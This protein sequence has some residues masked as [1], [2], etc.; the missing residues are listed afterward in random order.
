MGHSTAIVKLDLNELPAHPSPRTIMDAAVR[1]WQ[2]EEADRWDDPRHG[3]PELS[4]IA[5]ER[6]AYNLLEDD[7]DGRGKSQIIPITSD[8]AE[9]TSTVRLEVTAAE[10]KELRRGSYYRFI[11]EGRFGKAVVKVE[12]AQLPK[13]RAPRAAAT[14]GKAVTLYRIVNGNGHPVHGFAPSYSSQ[15]AA[16]SAAVDYMK[17]NPACSELAVEAFIRRDTGKAALVTITRPEPETATVS[18]KVTTQTPKPKAKV[19]GYIV[20]FDY[21]H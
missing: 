1:K 7:E 5:S 20:G 16:R 9:K 14:E 18:F 10:L 2:D 6:A 11:D 3:Y 19:T 8:Y 15:A 12:I 13:P 21:H 4:P 17:E